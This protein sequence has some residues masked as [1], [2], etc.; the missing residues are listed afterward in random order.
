MIITDTGVYPG[1]L[2]EEDVLI[3]TGMNVHACTGCFGCW[4]KTPGAC[5]LDDDIANM[6]EI[7]AKCDDLYIVSRC[8]Y[9]SYSP[10]VKTV[11]E[12]CLSYVH[13]DF[14][15][16]AG[17]M[18]HKKRYDH[19]IHISAFFYG[20]NIEEAEKETARELIRLNAI[21]LYGRVS[22]IMFFTDAL[23]IGGVQ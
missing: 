2:N 22:R 23:E 3:K 20:E 8:W 13:P 18:R 12:R 15:I 9:G 1:I 5:V 19:E 6:G 11:M 21:N 16:K 4:T 17:M 14:V 7:L 10:F